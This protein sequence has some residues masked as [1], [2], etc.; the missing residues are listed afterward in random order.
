[1]L[2]NEIEV[3]KGFFDKLISLM[4]NDPTYI[5]YK[6]KKFNNSREIL[7]FYFPN[8]NI[9]HDDLKYGY[10]E[11]E[12]AF[13]TMFLNGIIVPKNIDSA[14]YWLKRAYHDNN[15]NAFS[16]LC[17][18][19]LENNM[20]DELEMFCVDSARNYKD[21]EVIDYCNRHG[22]NYNEIH[23]TQSKLINEYIAFYERSPHSANK[24]EMDLIDNFLTTD[25][26]V[27]A[28]NYLLKLEPFANEKLAKLYFYAKNES[29]C[30]YED[31][32][33]DE[34]DDEKRKLLFKK[35][36]ISDTQIKVF[37]KFR[38]ELRLTEYEKLFVTKFVKDDSF[39]TNIEYE[40]P[41]YSVNYKRNNYKN[42]GEF[43]KI[44][45]RMLDSDHRLTYES[46]CEI[47]NYIIAK[48]SKQYE[49]SAK[50]Q[51]SETKEVVDVSDPILYMGKFHKRA[52]IF[53]GEISKNDKYDIRQAM[54]DSMLN[55]ILCEIVPNALVY[56]DISMEMHFADLLLKA[57]SDS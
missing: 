32:I 45:Y 51:K 53:D 44:L 46:A 7:D 33:C 1:M 18:I 27:D 11:A 30:N 2:N 16:L 23:P 57:E 25:N 36:Q 49:Q 8:K 6:N 34:L 21:Q 38:E 17:K 55:N 28:I 3:K 29:I 15:S 50:E 12:F 48:E 41:C 22:Y 5:S 14:I 47:V 54:Y 19:M 10:H 37:D 43:D 39:L 40:N 42:F 9:M 52:V 20:L 56:P 26:E 35:Y 4:E 24:E 31:E 13:A